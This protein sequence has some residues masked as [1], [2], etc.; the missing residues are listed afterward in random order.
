MGYFEYGVLVRSNM[1]W[2]RL[3]ELVRDHNGQSNEV[4]ERGVTC[5]EDI[6]FVQVFRFRRRV[7]VC[8]AIE[9]GQAA[10]ERFIRK[11]YPDVA[12]RVYWPFQKPRWWLD[13]KRQTV[14]WMAP[15]GEQPQQ[16]QQGG[17]SQEAR[18]GQHLTEDSARPSDNDEM[19][20][21][22]FMG[23]PRE[24]PARFAFLK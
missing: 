2:K 15:D 12:K 23:V 10:V 6:A 18:R 19:L 11:F 3:V 17:S 16:N 5:G 20:E 1:E 8:F 4:Y 14:L 22:R 13:L 7:Y 24:V 21:Y 9:D